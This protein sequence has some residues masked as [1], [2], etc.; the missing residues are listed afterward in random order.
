[1]IQIRAKKVKEGYAVNVDYIDIDTYSDVL[2][3]LCAIN[4][5]IIT[6]LHAK[7]PES[8]TLHKADYYGGVIAILNKLKQQDEEVSAD[9]VQVQRQSD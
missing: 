5:E 6:T 8:M 9:G 4:E 3:M 1:M 2:N 7:Q